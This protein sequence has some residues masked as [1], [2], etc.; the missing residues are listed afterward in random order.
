[1]ATAS[2]PGV[3]LA[4]QF[5]LG[6]QRRGGDRAGDNGRPPAVCCD[7]VLGQ[8]DLLLVGHEVDFGRHPAVKMPAE[9]S[10]MQKSVS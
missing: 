8:V 5:G 6:G 7:D 10:V 4:D 1:M 3:H 9:P 2:A